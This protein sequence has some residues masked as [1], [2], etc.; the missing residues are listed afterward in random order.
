MKKIFVIATL[1]VGIAIAS[2]SP[3]TTP[4]AA[5]AST[6]DV[7][8]GKDTYVAKCQRCHE[9]KNPGD[10]SSSRWVRIVDDMAPKAHL[11]DAEKAN[12][13]AYVQA[14]AKQ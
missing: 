12:V 10:F 5:T 13:L 6:G 3:K 9:L 7:A 11:D 2:C 1:V 8:A 14:H 4:P